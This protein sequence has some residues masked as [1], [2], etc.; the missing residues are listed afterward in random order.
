MVE[1]LEKLEDDRG[2][3]FINLF[4]VPETVSMEQLWIAFSDYRIDDIIPN[5]TIPNLFDIK[6]GSK[7]V[8]MKLIE[9]PEF[10][11]EGKRVLYRFSKLMRQ[12]E[13]QA[14]N[15]G[16]EGQKGG[17]R[18]GAENRAE[19]VW[20]LGTAERDS[21]FQLQKAGWGGESAARRAESWLQTD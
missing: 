5:R 15:R 17:P 20:Q 16:Q 3:Y 12:P 10:L 13:Q 6:V 4:N 1:E 9:K 8:F 14:G 21:F 2:A 18:E 19:Q 11:V 7:E